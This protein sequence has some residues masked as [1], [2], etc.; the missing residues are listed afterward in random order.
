MKLKQKHKILLISVLKPVD[1]PRM[2]EKMG[3]SLARINNLEVHI[4]GNLCSKQ[5]HDSHIQLHP[6]FKFGRSSMRRFYVPLKALAFLL[7]LKPDMVIASTHEVLLPAIF[8][9]LL[10]GKSVIYDVQ[11]NYYR[12]IRYGGNHL[13]LRIL[14]ANYTRIK[15]RLSHPFIDRYVLAEQ[16]YLAEMPWIKSKGTVIENKA[17]PIVVANRTKSNL[18]MVYTGIIGKTYGTLEA[19]YLAKK[20]LDEQDGTFTIVGF[21]PDS[22]YCN[23]VKKAIKNRKDIT[24]IGGDYF[25][26]HDILME[27]ASKANL[28]I[29]S[30]QNNVAIN[31]KIP[32]RIFEYMM[33]QLPMIIPDNPKWIAYCEAS[34]SAIPVVFSSP[35][36]ANILSQW[37]ER[38]FYKHAKSSYISWI[39]EEVKLQ[40]IISN[41]LK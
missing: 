40:V 22:A 36:V 35:D 39:N 26:D 23:K 4:A 2:Y 21:S 9:K 3:R 15:E 1:E 28:A 7:K 33:L 25:V 5:R 37:K 30:Y 6:I 10:F 29:I 41:I 13:I 34:N 27:E 24:L 17:L 11:E 18:H 38:S 19:I 14:L 20:I 12:N 16:C 31:D 32:T 8:Y